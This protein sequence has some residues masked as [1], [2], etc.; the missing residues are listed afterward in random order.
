[1]ERKVGNKIIRD[2]ANAIIQFHPKDK[3]ERRKGIIFQKKGKWR[4][5]G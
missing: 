2:N 3:V 5:L 4:V 1:V